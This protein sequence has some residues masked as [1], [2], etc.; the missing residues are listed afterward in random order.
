MALI[1]LGEVILT[2][3]PLD[4]IRECDGKIWKKLIEK[5][6]LESYTGDYELVMHRLYAGKYQ[7]HV[8]AEENPR[9]GFEY[10]EPNLEDVYFRHIPYSSAK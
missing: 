10:V 7:I 3:N 6:E 1:N 2:A 5:H 4:T 9:N 8:F